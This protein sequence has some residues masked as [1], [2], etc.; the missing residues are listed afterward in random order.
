MKKHWEPILRILFDAALVTCGTLATV[1]AVPTS[2]HIP[3]ELL[4]LIWIFAVGA[5]LLSA[6]M[7]VKRG[8]LVYAAV[9]VIAVVAY[10]VLDREAIKTG[11]C[12]AWN[13]VAG[14]LSMDFAFL[15]TIELEEEVLFAT[16]DITSFLLIV[17]LV[18]SVLLAFALIHGR[19]ALLSVLVPLPPFL[20]S[21]I[22]T[23]QPPALWTAILLTVFCAGA[24]LGQGVRKGNAKRT[25]LYLAVL[26]PLITAFVLLIAALS[27]QE[28]F[29]PIPFE[30]RKEMLGDRVD[31]IGDTV[32][33]WFR[34]NP[35]RY[36]LNDINDRKETD[37]KAF[38]VRSTASG[39]YL[40]RSHSYGQYA[41]GVWQQAPEYDGKWVAMSALGMHGTGV[42]AT[43]SIK[44]AVSSERYVPYA[45]FPEEGQ[46]IGESAVP[47]A[48]RI[49]Y[50][51]NFAAATD[52]T[53]SKVTTAEREYVAFA[54]QQYT[55]PDGAYKQTLLQ[56]A[57]EAGLYAQSNPYNTAR[58][59]AS[60]VQHSGTYSLTP[61]AVPDGEDFVLYF[62]TESHSGYC[63]HFASA[64]AALLQ[65]MDIP[66]RY[67]TGYRAVVPNTNTWIDVYE[68]SAH[69]W[70][71]VY[72]QGVGWIPIESTAGFTYEL[73]TS[74]NM[75]ITVT[76][77]PT[78]RPSA[79]PTANATEE[80][81]ETLPPLRSPR[82]SARADATP[83]PTE[84]PLFIEN[85]VQPAESKR[86]ST[87]WIVPLLLP[88]LIAAWIGF[89]M[90][91][92]E[93]RAKA[94][95]QKNARKAVLAMLRYL[96]RLERFGV[97][98]E[99]QADEWAEE[100]AFSDHP[101]TETRKYLL[102]KIKTT[103]S[104]LYRNA[105]HKRFF[106]KWVLL[107]I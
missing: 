67:T 17:G 21:M 73:Q 72:Q 70:V 10:G 102:S 27:P 79:A 36:D 40:L 13:G 3:F 92:R 62:L 54:E 51:W 19:M 68:H 83:A 71:E 56:L 22:Y 29:T 26:V 43:L 107:A 35:K 100:A 20:L 106:V 24:L 61:G 6:C 75:T 63:V 78:P 57:R 103:Q 64:T 98:R 23:D 42:G 4:T 38:S 39:T 44:N 60:Y 48:G 65:A 80:P 31:S 77:R 18:F 81:E 45:F 88:I 96:E 99:E 66:A 89:G 95:R 105:P 12:L 25:G 101:M 74:T 86:V 30:Q 94:F 14:P 11:A 37:S 50:A 53:P 97:E 16:A 49:S 82:P 2:F 59:V 84:A 58:A 76:P 32:L 8:K 90:L 104:T 41:N 28:S 55:M 69:A 46:N 93:R 9:F 15:Q 91:L 7:H 34:M 1:C 47:A 52:L 85:T 87:W 33:S 5:L